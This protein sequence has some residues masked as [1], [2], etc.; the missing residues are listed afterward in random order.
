MKRTYIRTLTYCRVC[1]KQW[2]RRYFK[3]EMS[4]FDDL[5]SERSRDT[6]QRLNTAQHQHLLY[7]FFTEDGVFRVLCRKHIVEYA[8]IS[9]Y[10][11]NE[12]ILEARHRN[13]P[14]ISLVD[15]PQKK[16]NSPAH[17][18]IPQKV[19]TFLLDFLEDNSL[20]LSSHKGY[21]LDARFNTKRGLFREFSKQLHERHSLSISEPTFHTYWKKLRPDIMMHTH[22]ECVCNICSEFHSNEEKHRGKT[23]EAG[24]NS[25]MNP[26][27]SSLIFRVPAAQKVTR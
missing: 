21:S 5:N 4:S 19:V 12:L 18:L 20:P 2:S 9:Q 25:I 11:V 13:D 3:D 23:S 1:R 26:S 17:N 14:Q 6:L 22:H 10:K 8:S 7:R 16:I 15:S 27:L 24:S